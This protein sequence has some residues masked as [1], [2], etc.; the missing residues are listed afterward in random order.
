MCKTK[1]ARSLPLST[2]IEGR[3]EENGLSQ[4]H[5]WLV[6]RCCWEAQLPSFWVYG[7]LH[8]KKANQQK[9]AQESRRARSAENLLKS[10]HRTGLFDADVLDLTRGNLWEVMIQIPIVFSKWCICAQKFQCEM[11]SVKQALQAPPLDFSAGEFW[12][13]SFRV[14]GKIPSENSAIG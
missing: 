10:L 11:M 14:Y 1:P 12:L 9:V 8:E 13:W 5:K 7:K 4:S 3:I 6:V 2:Y